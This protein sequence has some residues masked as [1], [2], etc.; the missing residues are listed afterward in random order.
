MECEWVRL[1]AAKFLWAQFR[2]NSHWQGWGR[3]LC[4]AGIGARPW[5]E[6][7]ISINRWGEGWQAETSRTQSGASWCCGSQVRYKGRGGLRDSSVPQ[8]SHGSKAQAPSAA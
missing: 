6:G 5:E 1:P 2:R 8:N 3:R 7:R 4:E